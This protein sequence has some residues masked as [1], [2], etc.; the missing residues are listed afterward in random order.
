MP[1]R[2]TAANQKSSP[3]GETK[4]AP[5]EDRFYEIT[6]VCAKKNDPQDTPGQAGRHRH[7]GRS[8]RIFRINRKAL[9]FLGYSPLQKEAREKVYIAGTH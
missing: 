6:T 1:Y 9:R 7:T 3:G 8:Q 2:Q 5:G 4:T